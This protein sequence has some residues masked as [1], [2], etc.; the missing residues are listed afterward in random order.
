MFTALRTRRGVDLSEF[1]SRFG[2]PFFTVYKDKA[3][4]IKKYIDDGL[5]VLSGNM[6][7]LTEEG[8]DVSNDIMSEF[9]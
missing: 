7:S 9:V 1:E 6:L 5:M 2:E 4:L 8:I 3:D